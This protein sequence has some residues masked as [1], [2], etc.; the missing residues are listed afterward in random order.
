M[1]RRLLFFVCLAFASPAFALD[2]L[3][4]GMNT[5]PGTLNPLLNSMLSGAFINSVTERPITAFD[6]DWKLVCLLCTE[7]PTVENGRARVVD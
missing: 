6:P 4:I 1:L 2:E 5:A 3:V 7:L